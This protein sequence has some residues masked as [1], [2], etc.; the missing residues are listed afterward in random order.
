[1]HLCSLYDFHLCTDTSA[2]ADYNTGMTIVWLRHAC[3]YVKAAFA[4]AFEAELKQLLSGSAS[5]LNV[6]VRRPT[7]PLATIDYI[8]LSAHSAIPV[9]LSSELYTVLHTRTWLTHL[10]SHQQACAQA[11]CKPY[12]PVNSDPRICHAGTWGMSFRSHLQA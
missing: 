12:N 9:Y 2:C 7:L 10:Y 6:K 5:A 1:M 3:R 11:S 8:V 4:Q